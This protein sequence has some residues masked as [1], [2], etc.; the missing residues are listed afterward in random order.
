MSKG[1]NDYLTIRDVLTNFELDDVITLHMRSGREFNGAMMEWDWEG[2][3][4]SIRDIQNQKL[5][6]VRI[7]AIDAVGRAA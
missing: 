7:D 5:I 3:I 4:V 2:E 1:H 6:E